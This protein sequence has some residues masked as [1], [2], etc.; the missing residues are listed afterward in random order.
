LLFPE[1]LDDYHNERYQRYN[2]LRLLQTPPTHD[3]L[4]VCAGRF[5]QLAAEMGWP[6]THLTSVLNERNGQP[7]RY[8]RVVVDPISSYSAA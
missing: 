7:V 1:K 6:I 5:V 3:G 2:L 8:W 4:Y